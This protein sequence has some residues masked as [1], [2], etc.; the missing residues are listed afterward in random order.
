MVVSAAVASPGILLEMH[1]FFL[2]LFIIFICLAVLG[3]KVESCRIQF[4]DQEWNLVPPPLEAWSFSHWTTREV[5]RCEFS[6][7][8]TE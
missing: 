7:P 6:N 4:S 1:I 2:L 3:L 8:T 5:P